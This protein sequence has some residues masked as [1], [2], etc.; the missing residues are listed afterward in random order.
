MNRHLLITTALVLALLAG[1]PA[2]AGDNCSVRDVAGNWTF[3]TGIGRQMLGE[4]FPPEKDIAAIGT[5]NIARGLIRGDREH[6]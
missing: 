5:M 1:R 4:P 3:A 2:A 6:D